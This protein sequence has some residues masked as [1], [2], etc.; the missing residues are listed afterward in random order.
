MNLAFESFEPINVKSGR[1]TV[2]DVAS[3]QHYLELIT[4]FKD[5]TDQLHVSADDWEL[6]QTSKLSYWL[7]DPML[8]LDL[9]KVFMKMVL[10]RL[11]VLATDEWSQLADEVRIVKTHV[12]ETSYLLDLPLEVSSSL[13]L[14]AVIKSAGLTIPEHVNQ[15]PY[16]KM[17]TLIKIITEINE[18][19]M[20]VLTNVSHYLNVTQFCQL[21]EVVADAQVPLLLI[22]FSNCNR[23]TMFEK[24]DY[25]YI[26]KDF[27]DW[28]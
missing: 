4:G 26:D 22:E 25:I 3:P 2:V 9:N 12:L 7:G 20:L 13:S 5:D 16:V 8:E 11:S 14:E 10:A 18:Q 17:E 6:A 24:C 1:V 28:R 19:R 21:A 23:R 27:V 15:D